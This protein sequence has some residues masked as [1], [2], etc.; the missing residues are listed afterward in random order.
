MTDPTYVHVMP[1]DGSDV[2]DHIE[3]SKCWCVP[4]KDPCEFPNDNE[5][6]VH[7]KFLEDKEAEG[8]VKP[9]S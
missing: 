6:W 7:N 4:V 2:K 3:S 1:V 5:V 9:Q 8:L